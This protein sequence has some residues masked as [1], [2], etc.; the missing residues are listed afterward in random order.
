MVSYINKHGKPTANAGANQVALG[1]NYF[2]SKRKDV[3]VSFAK[4]NNKAPIVIGLSGYRVG[5][6]TEQ[7]SGNKAFNVGLRHV[8]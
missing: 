5:H 4:I 1:Y 7:G 3:Y 8:F 6:A 2:L